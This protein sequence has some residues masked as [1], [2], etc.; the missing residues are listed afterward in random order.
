[1]MR[2]KPASLS[3][4]LIGFSLLAPVALSSAQTPASQ[5]K[6]SDSKK[7]T[8]PQASLSGCID[9]QEG[10]YVLIDDRTMK[11][12]ADLDADGFPTEGFAKHMGHKVTIRGTSSPGSTRT[13]F[14][15]RSIE[16]ISESCA[17]TAPSDKK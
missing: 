17:T 14:K 4:L 15:V 10:H 11:P 2:P 3:L 9:Q 16:T 1:M 5:K 6:G 13:A 12:V 8:V 7:K